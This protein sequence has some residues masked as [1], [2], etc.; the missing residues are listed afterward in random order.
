MDQVAVVINQH[1]RTPCVD[2]MRCLGR[3]QAKH[4]GDGVALP[5][6]GHGKE[7]E[8]AR[9]IAAAHLQEP[10]RRGEIDNERRVRVAAV[11]ERLYLLS[12]RHQRVLDAEK[13]TRLALE[14]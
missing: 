5:S 3:Q 2:A 11:A 7:L 6:A 8:V 9:H 12:D 10:S 1:P 14:L 13:L 4:D